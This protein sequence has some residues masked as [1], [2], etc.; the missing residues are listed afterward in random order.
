MRVCAHV[1]ACVRLSFQLKTRLTNFTEP[2]LKA[3]AFESSSM[4]YL[5]VSLH[6]ERTT[7][8]TSET[9]QMERYSQNLFWALDCRTVTHCDKKCNLAYG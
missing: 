3:A 2:G 9:V 5:L 4:L 8:Q 7:W 1:R 6:S